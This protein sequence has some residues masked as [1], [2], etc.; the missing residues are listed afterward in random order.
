MTSTEEGYAEAG[1][2]NGEAPDAPLRLVV[3]DYLTLGN[4]LCGFMA[5][6]AL[7]AAQ[8]SHFSPESVGPLER[9]GVAAAVALLLIATAFDLFDGRVARKLGGSGMGAELDNLADVIS[10]GFAPAF[11]V[12]TW[13]AL[14]AGIQGGFAVA[15]AAGV[16]LAVVVRLARFSAQA[17]GSDY[18]IGLPS[19]FG[20]MSVIVIVLLDPPMLVGAVAILAVAWLMVSRIEY[21]KPKG[22]LAFASFALIL[23][24]IVCIVAWAVN[25]PFGEILLYSG[26]GFVLLLLLAVPVYVVVTRRHGARDDEDEDTADLPPFPGDDPEADPA[27][28]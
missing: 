8:V 20:A 3:A 27:T 16:L 26:A 21:P 24:G 5:V 9:S 22:R 18:F 2:D 28:A 14:G 17:P 7:A 1:G 19:P 23:G 6:W 15:A 25:F 11:F 4:A 13:G 12:V 10:F